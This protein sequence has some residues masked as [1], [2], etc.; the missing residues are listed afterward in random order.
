MDPG[1]WDVHWPDSAGDQVVVRFGRSLHR[2]A[3]I[4]TFSPASASVNGWSLHVH[5]DLEDLAANSIRRPFDRDLRDL[6]PVRRCPVVR[7]CTPPS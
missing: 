6:E 5:P 1:R 2:E 3:A 7:Q 4:W